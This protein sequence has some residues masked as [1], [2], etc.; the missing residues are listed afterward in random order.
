[1]TA[2]TWS[3]ILAGWSVFLVA[4][5]I[6]TPLAGLCALLFVF[7]TLYAVALVQVARRG[8][9]HPDTQPTNQ[10]GAFDEH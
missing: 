5:F 10:P 9:T 8:V 4:L 3:I 2:A 1:M 6:L 7:M